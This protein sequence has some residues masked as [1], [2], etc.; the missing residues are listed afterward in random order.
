MKTPKQVNRNL[1]QKVSQMEE[2]LPHPITSDPILTGQT[3]PIH[4]TQRIG[5]FLTLSDPIIPNHE[6]LLPD[7]SSKRMKLTSPIPT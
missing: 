2:K 3:M 1:F 7:F 5:T 6:S 4:K